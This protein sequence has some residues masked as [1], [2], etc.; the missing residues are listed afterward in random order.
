MLRI[1]AFAPAVASL[2][3]PEQ[4]GTGADVWYL[5]ANGW[6]VK[7]G[8]KLLIFDYQE[9]TDPS[10]PAP[11]EARNLDRGYVNADEPGTFET[12]VFV[13][14]QHFDHFDQVI[15]DW[16]EQV[17][18]VTYLLGWQATH[19]P[20]HHYFADQ[21]AHADVDGMEVY[22]STHITAVCPK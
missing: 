8:Q 21:R 22:T 14:H 5:G 6:A 11:G 18:S 19:D 10:P 20:A 4:T 13:T 9:Q 16:S 1:H 15:F 17:E 12:Y 7:I 2:A 3:A